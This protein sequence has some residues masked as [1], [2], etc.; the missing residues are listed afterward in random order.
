[1]GI[2]VANPAGAK[3]LLCGCQA[4]VFHSNGD[5]DVAVRFAVGTHPFLI[6]E[7]G[8]D[9]VQRRFVEP[10]PRVA[11]LQIRPT[12]LASD[13]AELPRLAVHSRRSKLHTLLDVR[14][15]LLLYRFVL[16]RATAVAVTN[17]VD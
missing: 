14:N 1:M 13:N 6:M 7:R 12:L 3:P 15:F 10:R 2:E 16:I 17:D 4:K 5:I 11:S 8:G 9:D